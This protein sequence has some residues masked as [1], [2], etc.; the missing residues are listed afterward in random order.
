MMEC[1][2]CGYALSPFEKACPRCAKN[3]LNKTQG[4]QPSTAPHRTLVYC[5]NPYCK[6]PIPLGATFCQ[7]CGTAQSVAPPPVQPPSQYHAP[8]QQYY[9]SPQYP[10][11]SVQSPINSGLIA[12]MWVFTILQAIVLVSGGMGGFALAFILDVPALIMAICLVCTK[13]VAN[14]ANGWVKIGLE[15][16]AAIS[17]A[18]APHQPAPITLLPSVPS[19]SDGRILVTPDPPSQPAPITL[20]PSAPQNSEGDTGFAPDHPRNGTPQNSPPLTGDTS[21]TAPI[22]PVTIAIRFA[23]PLRNARQKQ[24]D[25]PLDRT[26]SS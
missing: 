5:L 7:Y 19:S 22:T 12:G 25:V 2:E 15:V 3:D 24:I 10:P 23:I 11:P 20:P 14:R 1:P 9:M 21:F 6:Q 4:S 26:G 17:V 16:L 8:P 18:G 13:N